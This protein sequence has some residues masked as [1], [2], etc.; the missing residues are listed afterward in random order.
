M[1]VNGRFVTPSGDAQAVAVRGG[2]IIAVG[3]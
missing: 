1:Y 2:R 3:S